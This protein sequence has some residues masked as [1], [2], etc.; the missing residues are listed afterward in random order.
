MRP[1]MFGDS[2]DF[3]KKTLIQTLA[4][5]WMTHP[6][7]FDTEP[8]QGFVQAHAQ[9]LGVGLANGDRNRRDAVEQ[10]GMECRHHLLLD[11][12]TGVWARQRQRQP[13]GGWNK[14]LRVREVARIASAPGRENLLTLV[15]DQSYTRTKHDERYQLVLNKLADLQDHHEQ[16]QGQPR[17]RGPLHGAAYVTHAVFIWVSLNGDLVEGAKRQ[18]LERTQLPKWRVVTTADIGQDKD[19]E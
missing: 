4:E 9:Y 16:C 17:C 12:D 8:Q 2:Y 10:V 3:L 11:P 15:F 19:A 18:M 7:Y 6:M 14:H 5:G 13:N 1:E